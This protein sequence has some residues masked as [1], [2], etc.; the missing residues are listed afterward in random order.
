MKNNSKTVEEYID[1]LPEEKQET[2]RS[3]RNF[4]L[5]HLPEGYEETILWSMISYVVPLSRYPVTYNK[6]PLGYISIAAQK[7]YYSMYLLGVYSNPNEE[8][9]FREEY[10]KTGK[11]IDM[12]KS[13]LIFKS[14]DDIPLDFLGK[15]ISE[16]SVEDLIK[17]YEDSRKK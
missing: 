6:Q 9:K 16:T 10:E 17:R 15:V 14:I 4:V 5:K 7:N 11:K 1:S 12:G 2:V 8:K 3:L 13:C